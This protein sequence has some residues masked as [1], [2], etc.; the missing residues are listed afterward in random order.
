MPI[1]TRSHTVSLSIELHPSTN[2]PHDFG[3]DLS[4]TAVLAD[5]HSIFHRMREEVPVHYSRA[6]RAWIVTRYQDVLGA[7]RDPRL[8]SDRIPSILDGQVAAKDRRHVKDFE[9]TRSAMMVNMD[10]PDHHR[11]RRLINP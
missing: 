10:G 3:A 5:P 1:G 9:R 6:L 8:S 11:L 2:A 4:N 7:L